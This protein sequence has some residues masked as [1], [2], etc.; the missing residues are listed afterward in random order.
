MRYLFLVLLLLLPLQAFAVPDCSF[1][2]SVTD[3]DSD[4]R[5]AC[6]LADYSDVTINPG[7]P[8][9]K[10]IPFG[11]VGCTGEFG[12][13]SA[14]MPSG[15]VS[16]VGDFVNFV[17]PTTPGSYTADVTCINSL[18]KVNTF[19]VNVGGGL[20]ANVPAHWDVMPQSRAQELVAGGSTC[21][22][23]G[24][25]N[26]NQ[27]WCVT[28]SNYLTEIPSIMSNPNFDAGDAIVMRAGTYQYAV[29]SLG[30]KAID[31]SK[32]L[33]SCDN[34]NSGTML[35]LNNYPG[36]A[37]LMD[38]EP[39]L[40]GTPNWNTCGSATSCAVTAFG[41]KTAIALTGD[42]WRIQSDQRP[43]NFRIHGWSD[44]GI[45]LNGDNVHV[46]GVDIRYNYQRGN[47]FVAYDAHAID[48][49]DG[50]TY[51]RDGAGTTYSP[52][53][54]YPDVT[55][56]S[57]KWST[58][59]A[60]GRKSNVMIHDDP[61][62]MEIYD[63]EI[64]YNIGAFGG[65]RPDLTDYLPS[66]GGDPTGG[67]NADIFT[68]AAACYERETGSSS[69]PDALYPECYNGIIKRNYMAYGADDCFDGQGY[70][71]TFQ[72]NFAHSCGDRGSGGWKTKATPP[73]NDQTYVRNW[74]H[75]GNVTGSFLYQTKLATGA[76]FQMYNNGAYYRDIPSSGTDRGFERLGSGDISA[77]N[78]ASA[79]GTNY[80]GAKDASDLEPAVSEYEN[81]SS[82]VSHDAAFILAV[83]DSNKTPLEKLADLIV[84]LAR[85]Y[86]PTAG[87][88]MIDAGDETLTDY[89]GDPIFCATAG[90]VST[91]CEPWNGAAPDAGPI[92]RGL[93]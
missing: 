29:E 34:A 78:V 62:P 67:G 8:F 83:V 14:T 72:G 66:Q 4:D 81:P 89:K 76:T 7:E 57:I 3:G 20:S 13:E 16:V 58:L 50:L 27:L 61:D 90:Q 44:S 86:E 85:D 41:R 87:S 43:H 69:E 46:W 10:Y 11:F 26:D 31:L 39:E 24:T 28:D 51:D 6:I 17:G 12:Q 48:D 40:T 59:I 64:A 36:E 32:Q 79:N 63:W 91:T 88:T 45:V 75:G 70:N 84:P 25:T 47:I 73:D 80:Q 52:D 15:S 54:P 53:G 21:P 71:L 55:N 49:S 60:G 68:L 37:V 33:G 19:Q 42:C 77:H 23:T 35:H 74:T 2:G 82:T 9:T 65:Y 30:S 18:T 5:P 1:D 93:Y 22:A 38:G 56:W 92:E